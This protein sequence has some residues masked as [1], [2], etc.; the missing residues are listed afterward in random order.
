MTATAHAL[1]LTP[2]TVSQQLKLLAHDMGVS[3]LEPDGRRVRL[4]PA[5]EILLNTPICC[6]RNGKGPRSTWPRSRRAA[7]ESCGYADCRARSSAFIAP[8][9]KQLR[10]ANPGVRLRLAAVEA[11]RRSRCSKP[12]SRY[13]RR[14]PTDATPPPSD[15]RFEQ[16]VLVDDVEDLLV[17]SGTGWRAERA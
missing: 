11:P 14:H 12:A 17:R 3:L 4:T 7:S 16:Q 8:A 15:P 9:A 10:E 2:S 5:A 13:R 1:H 6:T